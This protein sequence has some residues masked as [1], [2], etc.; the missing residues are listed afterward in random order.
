[1]SKYNLVEHT[2]AHMTRVQFGLPR[3]KSFYPSEASAV[4]TDSHGIKRVSGG[5]LRKSWY[6]LSGQYKADKNDAYSEWI[7]ALGK[8]VEEILVEQWKQMGIWVNNNVKFYVPDKNISGELDTVLREPDGTLF[9]VEVKSFAGYQATKSIMGNKST[10]GKPKDSQ[11]MQ[12][13]I[14][15]DLC[16]QLGII[17]YFKMIYYARDSGA[18]REFNITLTQDGEHKRPTVDGVVDF[19]FTMQDIY[20]R[21]AQL[22]QF[23]SSD[24]PPPRDFE[25]VWDKDTVEM[26]NSIG[27][28]AKTTYEKWK[29][30]PQAN[31]IGDWQCRWCSF[32]KVCYNNKD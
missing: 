29:R 21:Y 31:P 18:R 5:C 25:I 22:K 26:R 13:L 8:A 20:D 1:M 30:N 3:M 4:Y 6:R 12:C 32:N 27:E 19:R 23:A 2:D 10:K 16:S 7:F 11:L 24:A 9:G 15:V 17:D 28:I 14:Y